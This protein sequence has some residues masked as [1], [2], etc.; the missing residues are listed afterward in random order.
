[1]L[2]GASVRALYSLSIV[3][4]GCFFDCWS[5]VLYE[6]PHC[7][8]KS[9]AKVI[10]QRICADPYVDLVGLQSLFGMNDNAVE[11]VLDAFPPCAHHLS[12]PVAFLVSRV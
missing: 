4:T 9:T 2:F 12:L 6:A 3:A 7:F 10:V 1:M 8:G 11:K 5:D